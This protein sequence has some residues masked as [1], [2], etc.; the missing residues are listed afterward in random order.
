MGRIA[1]ETNQRANQHG[2]LNA[3]TSAL[4]SRSNISHRNLRIHKRSSTAQPASINLQH[5]TRGPHGH[6]SSRHDQHPM[7]PA[8]SVGTVPQMRL[9]GSTRQDP[10]PSNMPHRD[11]GASNAAGVVCAG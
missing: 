2:L 3:A 1:L 10:D 7:A 11:R 8:R 9:H 6:N 5:K 4:T